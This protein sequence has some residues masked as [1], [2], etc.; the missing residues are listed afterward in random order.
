MRKTLTHNIPR[1]NMSSTRHFFAT[2]CSL[3][4]L[5]LF[6]FLGLVGFVGTLFPFL[7]FLDHGVRPRLEGAARLHYLGGGLGIA[8]GGRRG[9]A[10]RLRAAA[11]GIRHA[12]LQRAQSVL[13]LLSG[14]VPNGHV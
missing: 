6:L 7:W 10:S 11:R 2:V 1:Q 14:R 12:V 8:S 9:R 13:D 4:I 5:F 3:R